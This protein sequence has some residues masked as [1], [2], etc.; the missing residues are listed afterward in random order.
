MMQGEK[1]KRFECFSVP[2]P[3]SDVEPKQTRNLELHRFHKE[4]FRPSASPHSPSPG[5]ML[6]RVVGQK[7]PAS[8]SERQQFSFPTLVPLHFP[9]RDGRPGPAHITGLRMVI[10]TPGNRHTTRQVY[11]SDDRLTEK[12]QVTQ[13]Q[14]HISLKVDLSFI[15]QNRKLNGSPIL[16]ASPSS[17]DCADQTEMLSLRPHH[18]VSRE[19]TRLTAVG[20]SLGVSSKWR[21]YSHRSEIRR[22]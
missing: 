11:T 4:P 8:I 6:C 22:A 20:E 10:A 9:S 17:G 12:G 18:R 7:L 3:A 13:D 15:P 21:R 2:P 5:H 14:I 19:S 1:T 16:P